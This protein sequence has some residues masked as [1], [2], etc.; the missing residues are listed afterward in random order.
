MLNKSY[1]S[2]P[3]NNYLNEEQ[4][5]EIFHHDF[6]LNILNEK[7]IYITKKY[8]ELVLSKYNL[9]HKVQNLKE[10]QKAVTHKSYINITNVTE[11]TVKL[12]KD[13]P[14]IEDP[15]SAIPLVENIKQTYGRLE[16]L[17]DAVIH[18][19]LA[20]YLFDRY[21]SEEEGFLTKLRTNLEKSHALA[22]LSRK[23]NLPKYAVI[24]RNIELSEG[25]DKDHLAEDL[26]EAFVGA[27]SR[28]ASYDDCKKFI[29]SIVENELDIADIISN[30]DNYKDQLMRH[31][32]KL[33]WEVP[34]YNDE[35]VD[36][37]NKIF[38]I[39][40]KNQDGK[41]IGI[42]TSNTKSNASKLAA[43]RALKYLGVL[44]E[45]EHNED[46]EIFGEMMEDNNEIFGELES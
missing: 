26:F 2:S 1:S 19:V 23:I 17:G 29:I 42:A 20:E 21:P 37:E 3:G 33:K 43:M 44:K 32:H 40:V 34:K 15:S 6:R 13:V 12:L 18:H 10:F 9:N 46:D 27:L 31:F 38:T 45:E 5:N 14:P 30:D 28:E 35:K 39:S 8:I 41:I 22:I 16:Y 7:N 4:L 24:A 11:K 36:L 25:R